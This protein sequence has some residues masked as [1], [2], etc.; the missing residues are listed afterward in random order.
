MENANGS[1]KAQRVHPA[2]TKLRYPEIQSGTLRSWKYRLISGKCHAHMQ[3]DDKLSNEEDEHSFLIS[4][5]WRTF[6]RLPLTL[7]RR[8][9]WRTAV[10]GCGALPATQGESRGWHLK[11][12]GIVRIAAL[13][14]L[15]VMRPLSVRVYPVRRLSRWRPPSHRFPLTIHACRI[16]LHSEL[17]SVVCREPR[18][19]QPCRRAKTYANCHFPAKR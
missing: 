12:V 13:D 17:V 19:A 2:S 10:S 4:E 5:A 7:D 6:F 8:P 15:R 3:T 18:C 1:T 11:R 9:R 16:V 14:G